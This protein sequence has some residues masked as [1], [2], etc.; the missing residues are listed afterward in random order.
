MTSKRSN[1]S[2]YFATA[3]LIGLDGNVVEEGL[4]GCQVM[5]ATD[6]GDASSSS[7]TSVYFAFTDLRIMYQGTFRIRVDT[8]KAP[9]GTQAGAILDREV[10]SDQI[11]VVSGEVSRQRPSS[12]ERST[13]RRLREAGVA[14]SSSSGS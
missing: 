10:E 9:Q 1:P 2:G 11:T 12:A 13:I 5:S 6:V 8:Y 7:R 4:D 14:I 3:S